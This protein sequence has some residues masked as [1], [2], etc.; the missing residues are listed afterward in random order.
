M[1]KII[2]K[3]R[4]LKKNGSGKHSRNIIRYIATRDGVETIDETW[5]SK[6]ATKEQEEVIDQILSDFPSAADSHEYQDY[7]QERTRGTASE[8]ITRAIEDNSD[9]IGKRKNYVEY[10]AKRPRVE[11]SGEHGL[12]TD[13]DVKFNLSAV[14]NEVA[15]H[16]G[17]I[18]TEVLSLRREDA[19]RLGYDRGSSWR[20]LLRSQTDAMA[21]AMRIPLTDLRWYAAFHNEA[22]HP[23]VHIVA[24]SVGKEPYMTENGLH[25]LKSVFARE[26]FKQDLLEVYQEQ[27]LNRDALKLESKDMLSEISTQITGGSQDDQIIGRLLLDLAKRLEKTKGKRVYGYLSESTKRIVDS[28]VNEMA[29]NPQIEELYDRWYEQREK[30]VRTYTDEMPDRIPLSENEEFRSVKNAVIQEALHLIGTSDDSSENVD[31]KK[32][33]VITGVQKGDRNVLSPSD[34]ALSS[35]RLLA[36]IVQILS[37]E[38]YQ[39]NDEEVVESKVRQ[40][41]AEKKRRHGQKMG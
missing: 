16:D 21:R 20:T 11:R 23:H 24:Y 35:I 38:L 30:I 15:S 2:F 10:I 19:E 6:P 7:M 5:K 3:W 13:S 33:R 37:D 28:I 32:R 29:K 39:E 18:F 14:A 36:N 8:F 25:K 41:I 26:I 4:Y 1:A 22:H 31:E 12:F 27:T 40:Q 34:T 9:L 17:V